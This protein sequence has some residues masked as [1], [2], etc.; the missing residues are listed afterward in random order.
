MKYTVRAKVMGHQVTKDDAV[1]SIVR[2]VE[3]QSIWTDILV[4]VKFPLA[5]EVF[6]T[7]SD[8][9]PEGGTEDV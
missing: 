6:V 8:R 1:L 5:S 3:N 4:A 7:V 9:I 2:V